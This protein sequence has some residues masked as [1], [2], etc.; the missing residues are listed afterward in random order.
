V[1]EDTRAF[2]RIMDAFRLP[3]KSE[4]EKK[5]RKKS[6]DEATKNAILI[7]Y[8]VMEV[9]FNSMKVLEKM[10]KIGNPN[11]ISDVGVGTMAAR[12][13]VRGAF[14]N[15]KINAFGLDDKEFVENIIKKGTIMEQSAADK[16]VGILQIVESKL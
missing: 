15:V 13:C 1:D 2:N 4:D 9:A 14:L 8:R 16:E 11:S 6:I 10:A 3:K 5:F 7:P 12:A